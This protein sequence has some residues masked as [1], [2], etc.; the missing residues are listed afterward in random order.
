MQQSTLDDILNQQK[1][2]GQIKMIKIET[3]GA[4]IDVIKGA[5]NTLCQYDVPYIICEINRFG[6]QQMGTNETELR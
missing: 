6:L 1:D 2:I 3:E 5:I 4:E